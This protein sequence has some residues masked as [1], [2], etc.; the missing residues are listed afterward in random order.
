MILC[1]YYQHTLYETE[2]EIS[3]DGDSAILVKSH[4][5]TPIIVQWSSFFICTFV[6]FRAGVVVWLNWGNKLKIRFVP[7]SSSFI[8]GAEGRR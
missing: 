1:K 2:R 4:D 3:G 6:Q 5:G 8:A 7:F